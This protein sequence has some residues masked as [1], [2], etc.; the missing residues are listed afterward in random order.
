LIACA[1][2]ASLLVARA[3]ARQ[4]ELAIR[5]SLGAGRA[6]I[7]R[8][9]L[10]ESVMLSGAGGLAGL[11]IAGWTD[12][13]LMGFLPPDT[14]T[15]HLSP[16]PDWRVLLFA[17]GASCVT[18]ILFGLAPAL[19]A[20]G[21]DLAPTLK[22]Q[23]GAVVSGGHVRLR[24]VLVA[25]QV[26]LSLVLLV[27][28]GLF[29]RS[30]RNLR[31][32]GP[33][34]DSEN[35]ISFEVDPALSGYNGERAKN[36]YHLLTERLNA[37]PGVQSAGLASMR[38]LGFSEWDSSI[39][40]EGYNAKQGENVYAYMNAVSPG[41]FGTLGIPI[42]A[43]RDFTAQ[44][45]REI[46]HGPEAD[47]TVPVR[48][49]VNQTFVKK[50]LGG[51][52]PIGRRVGFGSDPGTKTDMEIIGLVKDV[53]YTSLRD[54]IPQQ[55]FVPYDSGKTVAGMTIYVRSRLNAEQ[56]FSAVRAQV[57]QID[58]NL[59]V[60]AMRTVDDQ[61]SNSLLLERLVASL[62]TVFG[63]LATLLAAIGLYGVMAFTVARRTREIGIRMAL[64]AF[65]RD[66][67]WMVMREVLVLVAAGAATGVAISLALSKAVQSQLFGVGGGD[68]WT[69]A[70]ATAGLAL[71]AA[72][73]G[74]LPA[75]RA[76]R[77]DPMTALRYE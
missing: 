51:A 63:A 59:P 41:Y 1:N 65:R 26:T 55:M 68:P 61:I 38:I 32:L 58:A 14:V 48:V 8:Q 12:R 72:L 31:N 40:V 37:M 28:A 5:Q 24:K 20:S 7:V 56:A 29:I 22:D 30:L 53:K 52:N 27:G 67:V 13:L 39:T 60:Y 3:A 10:V 18:G 2:V 36:F 4:R 46:Q 15:L 43:G 74:Y 23:A 76:S 21:Q 77:I 11:L 16:A 64:G 47:N 25:A 33:G 34:F 9:L 57:R 42:L 44:D 54:E 35:L 62:S 66:V 70:A 45:A 73:S 6:A 17:A 69:L 75:L 19:Q 71:V 49:I 50:Y